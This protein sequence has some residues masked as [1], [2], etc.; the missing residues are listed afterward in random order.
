MTLLKKESTEIIRSKKLLILIIIFAFIAISSPILAKIIPDL[1]KNTPNTAGIT[2]NLATP[3]WHDA[4]DQL[5]KNTAQFGLI[6]IIFMFAGAIAEEKNKKTLEMILTKPISRPHFVLAKLL[7]GAFYLTIVYLA[8]QVVFYLYTMSVFESFSISNFAWLSLFLLVW[9][10]V[11][12]TLTLFSSAV[13][14]SQLIG[15]ALAFGIS[16]VFTTVVGYI[17]ALNK[18]SPSYVISNYKDL[19][20]NGDFHPFLPSLYTSLGIIIVLIVLAVALF[21]KQEV[22][23]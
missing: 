2:F 20:S 22:E 7:S 1:L 5:V 23:R 13:A 21:S 18:Y 17:S 19:M 14:K 11:I 8:F 15:A 10:L 3:T 12:F 4:I 9:L 6:V 16:I